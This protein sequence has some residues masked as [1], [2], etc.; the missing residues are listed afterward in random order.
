[1]SKLADPEM[2]YRS[3]SRLPEKMYETSIGDIKWIKGQPGNYSLLEARSEGGSRAAKA[4]EDIYG[5]TLDTYVPATAKRLGINRE[6]PIIIDPNPKVEAYGSYNHNTNTMSLNPYYL[7]KE[8]V[9]KYPGKVWD[10]IIHELA[11]ES[12][13]DLNPDKTQGVPKEQ[14]WPPNISM[15]KVRDLFS[16]LSNKD[17][18]E[19]F[20]GPH[21]FGK[22]YVPAI[23]IAA[24][25]YADKMKEVGKKGGY[26]PYHPERDP[27]FENN[28][29]M[30]RIMRWLGMKDKEDQK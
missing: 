6:I 16:G 18:M 28:R 23:D 12:S 22:Y 1:M 20:S 11:H 14:V 3:P 5:K 29:D 25:E 10:T 2:A 17:A 9:R 30:V 13:G 21:F 7:N 27:R 19:A 8:T 15:E 24:E 4:L 26:T